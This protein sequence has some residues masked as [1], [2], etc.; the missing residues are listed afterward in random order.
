MLK[1]QRIKNQE[2]EKNSKDEDLV[3][4][5]KV[6]LSKDKAEKKRKSK[7]E[8]RDSFEIDD[9]GEIV[10][11]KNEDLSLDEVV[12]KR[13]ERKTKEESTSAKSSTN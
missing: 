6:S 12:I 13:K 2:V 10:K 5:E 11:E 1:F 3:K 4:R 7:R 9:T 8:D